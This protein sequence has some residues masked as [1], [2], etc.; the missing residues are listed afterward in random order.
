MNIDAGSIIAALMSGLALLLIAR[1]ANKL[2]KIDE[3]LESC[4][5]RR[6]YDQDCAE[7]ENWLKEHD[8]WKREYVSNR[9]HRLANVVHSL[10]LRAWPDRDPPDLR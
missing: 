7:R 2:D 5:K 1:V 6:E 3:K 10:Y 4:I 8:R 9:F